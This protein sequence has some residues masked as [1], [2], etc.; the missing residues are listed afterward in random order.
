M[1]CVS[2]RLVPKTEP[3]PLF[4]SSRSWEHRVEQSQRPPSSTEVEVAERQRVRKD[5]RCRHRP[6]FREDVNEVLQFRRG[7]LVRENTK[8]RSGYDWQVLH[9]AV[10]PVQSQVS[11][12]TPPTL[13]RKDR[14]RIMFQVSD[15]RKSESD[16]KDALDE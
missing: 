14:S 1:S 10:V 3:E 8:E 16:E 2:L 7:P 12:R 9:V 6:Y 11:R 15:S 13:R 4:P 5:P